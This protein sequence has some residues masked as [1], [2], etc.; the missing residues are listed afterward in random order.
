MALAG[1]PILVAQRDRLLEFL[2]EDARRPREF[3]L[4]LGGE[5]GEI[6]THGSAPDPNCAAVM[7][8]TNHPGFLPVVDKKA[9]T[10]SNF[11]ACQAVAKPRHSV[12]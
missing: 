12:R 1:L 8:D 3:V 5:M 11:T 6:V 2:H 10:D 7:P 9:R 4:L